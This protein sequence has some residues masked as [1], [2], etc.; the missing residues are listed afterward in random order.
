MRKTISNPERVCGE[1]NPFRVQRT[2]FFGVPRVLTT[3]ETL[4]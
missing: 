4:G 2:F 3:F 1:R